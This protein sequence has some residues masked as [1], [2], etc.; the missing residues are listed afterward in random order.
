MLIQLGCN[1]TLGRWKTYAMREADPRQVC[2]VLFPSTEAS[3]GA[4]WPRLRRWFSGGLGTRLQ[5]P[6][7]G[8]YV[9]VGLEVCMR[10]RGPWVS[11]S[12][13]LRTASV[14]PP[15]LPTAHLMRDASARVHQARVGETLGCVV[16]ICILASG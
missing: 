11:V 9:A 4:R 1:Y 6:G 15:H 10:Q 16:L 13:G 14:H 7:L 8:R 3:L 12:A 5:S 2:P